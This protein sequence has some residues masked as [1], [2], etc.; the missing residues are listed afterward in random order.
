MSEFLCC[1]QCGDLSMFD[2][3]QYINDKPIC[4]ACYNQDGNQPETY[5]STE[6]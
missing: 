2:S 5:L 3:T 6:K 1:D 4:P